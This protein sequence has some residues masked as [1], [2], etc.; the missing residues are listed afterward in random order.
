MS[1][2]A[3][4]TT[5]APVGRVLPILSDIDEVRELVYDNDYDCYRFVM[6]GGASATLSEELKIFDDEIETCF[7]IYESEDLRAQRFL[8]E[9]LSSLLSF[10]VTMFAPDSDEVV[11]ESNGD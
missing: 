6:D 3:G 11:A 7:A 8:F 4:I 5:D 10:R 9:V 1:T 2:S